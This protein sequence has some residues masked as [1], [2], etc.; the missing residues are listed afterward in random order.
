M[1]SD[2]F[3]GLVYRATGNTPYPY[4]E[5]LARDG[6]PEL[7]QIPTGCGKTLAAT[8]AWL[9]RRR[10]HAD[11]VVRAE[12]PHWLVFTLP[13]R[14]L[15]E[16]T[17]GAISRWVERLGLGDEIGV[18]RVMGGESRAQ[19]RWRDRPEQDAIFVGTLDML[20]SRALNRGYGASRFV[21]PID[22]GLFN[23]GCQWV[24]D[25]VQLMG[26]ALPTTRQLEGLRHVLGTAVTTRSMWMSATV[27]ERS[28]STVDL[29][30][31]GSIVE[32][33][34][35]DRE[36][37][38][39]TR[40]DA[41]KRV[42]EV[43][44]ADRAYEIA[45]AAAVR[46]AHRAGTLTLAVCNTV[47][48]A[49]QVFGVLTSH[50]R[51]GGPEVVLL[52][53]RF[54]PP[55]RAARASAA[56]A[57]V[58][59]SGPGRIVV[60]TQVVEAGVDISAT[61]LFSEAAPW[62]SV[63]QRAGRCNRDGL[64]SGARLLWAEPPKSPP[65]EA[66]D[67]A[68]SI[69]ALRELTGTEVTPETLRALT[70]DTTVVVHP[71]L[72]RRDLVGLF[73][74]T[75]DLSGND[76]D[77]S[78]FIRANDDT[79]VQIAWRV[80]MPANAGELPTRDELCSVAVG[81]AR[82]FLTGGKRRAWSFDQL[83][84]AWV[85]SDGRTIRPG[86][87]VVVLADEG[88]YD[89]AS[90]WDPTIKRAVPVVAP[91]ESSALGVADAAIDSDPLTFTAGRWV[92]LTEH[93]ADVEREAEM[94]G[95]AYGVDDLA[96]DHLRATVVAGRLHDIG[97]AHDVFQEMLLDTCG[98]D[99]AARADAQAGVPW[100]KSGGHSRS[101]NA[102][103]Y[104]RHELVSL[105][106]LLGDGRVALDGVAEPDLVRYLVAAHH[107][108]VRLSIRSLPDETPHPGGG[109]VAL[110]TCDGDK[111]ASVVIPGGEI[112]ACTLDLSPMELGD[113]PDGAPSWTARALTLR[114]R[115]DLGPFRLAF[116]EAVVRL[117]DW[118]VSASYD[119]DVT[120]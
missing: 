38:L 11:P 52:H 16:Q 2:D 42:E 92:G 29:P 105:L 93:L 45:V 19:D 118:R 47:D 49:R 4:Q 55:D 98:E 67:I 109:R 65:Y 66:A 27:D 15:V 91:A 89:P 95:G 99:T 108:R 59:R 62:P 96:H 75:P 90:G 12:T 87:V 57:D 70:V 25:E 56:L 113:G 107:G 71:V 44:I 100:A 18:Y 28:L 74:T 26:A 117:S 64:T 17:Y 111:V 13:M 54:R 60:S 86:L 46:D 48:R 32:L 83:T 80:E 69:T 110:G 63:V 73:D 31:V 103:R 24:F 82:R 112:P 116:L 6:L 35:T 106:I 36:S 1:Q 76:L 102:R 8:L 78:R 9:Y 84:G 30:E 33:G 14:T 3:A 40:L 101:R 79:D 115:P 23:S 51:E 21:W 88:G 39:R 61:V 114:D 7:L 50:D 53:S 22:F 5:R 41:P 94:L 85:R 81:D 34:D 10:F 120:R 68:A 104:F 58:D 72:R 119:E 20:V 37:D 97:K 43:A 77:V